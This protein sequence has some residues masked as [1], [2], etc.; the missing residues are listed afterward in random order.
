VKNEKRKEF[1]IRKNLKTGKNEPVPIQNGTLEMTR[2][3]VISLQSRKKDGLAYAGFEQLYDLK[4]KIYNVKQLTGD[5]LISF[6]P[7]HTQELKIALAN[8]H[9][10]DPYMKRITTFFTD[11][12]FGDEIKPRVVPLQIDTPKSREDNDILV[13]KIISKKEHEKLMG[14]ISKVN[15]ITDIEFHM[16]NLWQQSYVFGTAAAWK[17]LSLVELA[18]IARKYTIPEKTPL[19]IKPLYG[20]YLTNIH[21]DVDTFDPKYFEYINPNVT[22]DEVITAKGEPITEISLRANT[23]LRGQATFLPWERLIVVTRPNIGTTPNTEHYGISTILPILYISENIRR[24][25]EKILPEMN[26]GSYAGVGIFSVPE[27]SKYDIDQLA[28]DL[29]TAGTRIVLNSEIQYIEIPVDFKLDGMINQKISLI[30]SELMALGI[31]DSLFFPE[32]TNRSTVE[33]LINIWQ[34]IDLK[35]ERDELTRVMWKYWY[36]DLM[37]IAF[38]DEELI[39]LSL[40]VKLEFKNKTFTGF[41]DKAAPTLEAFKIGLLNKPES[42]IMFDHDPYAEYEEEEI[43]QVKI[44]SEIAKAQPEQTPFGGGSQPSKT[45]TKT[46]DAVSSG[47]KVSQSTSRSRGGTD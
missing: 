1:L 3:R 35:K 13:R 25:D 6:R 39:D 46:R 30:K 34:N 16:R 22:L 41:I 18:N 20:Y 24:I 40:T 12:V 19:K 15:Y 5:D 10:S 7:P 21:Q 31:P 14:L 4:K 28:E 27:D 47:K 9:E 36:M 42:R 2:A 8:A 38:P 23:K 11:Y 44:E 32:D 29:A 37:K 43:P 26:E 45:T 17:T 33:I